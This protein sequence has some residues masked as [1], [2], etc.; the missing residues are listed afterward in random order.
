M[1]T[2]ACT[3]TYL[4]DAV[5]AGSGVRADVVRSVLLALGPSLVL[6]LTSGSR[7]VR[8]PGVGR[9]HVRARQTGGALRVAGRS[10][11]GLRLRL[12]VCREVIDALNA[13]PFR[14]ATDAINPDTLPRE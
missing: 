3:F 1:A 2:S 10:G 11:R 12:S 13:P 9:F 14:L 7:S 8:L 6:L 5:A 4:S